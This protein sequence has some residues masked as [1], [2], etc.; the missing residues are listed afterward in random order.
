MIESI[1]TFT[2]ETNDG[3]APWSEVEAALEKIPEV[4]SFNQADA[5]ARFL[6]RLSGPAK[7][8]ITDLDLG[9]DAT[10]QTVT[11][12]LKLIYGHPVKTLRQ[13]RRK[14]FEIGSLNTPVLSK[15]FDQVMQHKLQI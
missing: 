15:K 8:C 6:S 5:I 13:I 12:K 4:K 9:K 3:S 10:L 11:S 2:G 7:A 1:P 14:H